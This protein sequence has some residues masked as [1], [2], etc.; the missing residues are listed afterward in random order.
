MAAVSG[1]DGGDGVHRRSRSASSCS[2]PA[3]TSTTRRSSGVGPFNE[4]NDPS[5]A[6]IGVYKFG[7]DNKYT[8]G[9]GGVRRG[10]LTSPDGLIPTEGRC[11]AIR[12]GPRCVRSRS[13]HATSTTSARW[14]D[15]PVSSAERPPE[16]ARAVGQDVVQLAHRLRHGERRRPRQRSHPGTRDG[17]SPP[18]FRSPMSTSGRG[19]PGRA[20]RSS[21]AAAR[22]SPGCTSGAS[23]RPS[24]RP[25]RLDD[26]D[27][28]RARLVAHE[29][30]PAVAR[31]AAPGA[32]RRSDGQV[33]HAPL[34]H[35]VPAEQRDAVGARRR[36]LVAG[37]GR[38]DAR[39]RRAGRR[40][41]GARARPSPRRPRPSGRRRATAAGRGP[42]PAARGRR[43]R[44]S[45]TASA[46]RSRS[47]S[48]SARRARVQDV[49]GGEAHPV[50]C[51]CRP[52]SPP[53]GV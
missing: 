31:P 14:S 48:P 53:V 20:R 12:T 28:R 41:T 15:R 43:R 40:R 10:R 34:A 46:N 21:A 51:S 24:R 11:G 27:E 37:R 3:R 52:A 45:R 44:A 36:L 6:F 4:D 13:A 22:S 32:R 2:R 38:P 1:A 7:A 5:S 19:S 25:R 23:R 42:P 29:R 16:A 49:E 17:R 8:L 26:R 30:R 39:A 9:Q 47:T 50:D 18:M 33:Q 35:R